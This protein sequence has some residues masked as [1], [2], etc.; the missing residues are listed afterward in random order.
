MSVQTPNDDFFLSRGG[1][2]GA[3]IGGG[4]GAAL[5]VHVGSRE[6]GSLLWATLASGAVQAVYLVAVTREPLDGTRPRLLLALPILSIGAA[7]V[8]DRATR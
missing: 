6:R 1:L 2:V 3:V 7:V 8:V 5:G 4:V